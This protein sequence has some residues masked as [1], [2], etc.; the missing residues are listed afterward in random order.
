MDSKLCDVN[1]D[2]R[3]RQQ[4]SCI[5][6][7]KFVTFI[8]FCTPES[9]EPKRGATK[10]RHAPAPMRPVHARPVRAR[11]RPH[12]CAP[13][14]RAPS[15]CAPSAPTHARPART[16]A[17]ECASALVPATPVRARTRTHTLIIICQP[18]A[19]SVR[20]AMAPQSF[21]GSV[22]RA[23]AHKVSQPHLDNESHMEA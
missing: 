2:F 7:S 8:H 1:K 3:R 22:A 12:A 6:G 11:M 16:R 4:G 18:L 20:A 15:A 23:A 10:E 19:T 21:K 14:T 13:S 5:F 17:R 9:P